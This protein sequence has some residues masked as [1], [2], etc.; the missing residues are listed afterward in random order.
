MEVILKQ[1]ISGLGKAG[2]V[3]KVKDG[4][5]RNFLMPNN[6]AMPVTQ[7]NLK[8]IEVEKQNR[9][10]QLEKARR[11]A[12]SLKDKLASFSLTMPVL[13]HEDEKLYG[14]IGPQDLTRALSDEGIQITEDMI[15][16]EEPIKALG[17]YEVPVELH[18]EIKTTIR[19]WVVKK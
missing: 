13:V 19:V 8:K 11:D 1:D 16:I 18:P 15:R 7:A 9:Q 10:L 6:L 12:Q 3:V 2:A 14:S 17:I 4:F 5:A